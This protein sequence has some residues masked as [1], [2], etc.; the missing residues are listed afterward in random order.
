MDAEKHGKARRRKRPTGAKKS[1]KMSKRH[2][3]LIKR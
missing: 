1:E 3:M 2:S